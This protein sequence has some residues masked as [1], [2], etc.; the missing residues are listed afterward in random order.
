MAEQLRY[1]FVAHYVDGTCFRQPAD[2]TSRVNPRK[3]AYFDVRHAD[4]IRF[5]LLGRGQRLVVNLETGDFMIDG[6]IVK[7]GC[8]VAERRRLVYFRRHTHTVCD[9]EVVHRIS[10]VLG[11]ETT[12]QRFVIQ[13]EG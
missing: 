13:V 5:E 7:P 10:Y 1:L 2:D 4:L 9:G 11:W 12:D 3:S 8:A 6:R